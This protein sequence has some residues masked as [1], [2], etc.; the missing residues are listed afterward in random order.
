VSESDRGRMQPPRIPA[1]QVRRTLEAV[2][3]RFELDDAY[4]TFGNT[5]IHGA[6]KIAL[7]IR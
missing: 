7:K 1:H 6:L 2:T 5:V 4:A 3:H